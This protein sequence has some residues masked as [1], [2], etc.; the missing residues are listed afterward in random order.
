MTAPDLGAAL[1]HVDRGP[2]GAGGLIA[3][4]ELVVRQRRVERELGVE[5]VG[6]AP[7]PRRE[8]CA[9]VVGD[10]VHEPLVGVEE[11]EVAGGRVVEIDAVVDPERLGR[12][13]PALLRN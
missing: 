9:G 11:P 1:D 2:V 6:E 12:L 3:L 5:D 4:A 13:D 10:Q 7:A 8:V